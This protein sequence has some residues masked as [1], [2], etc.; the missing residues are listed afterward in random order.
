MPHIL[1]SRHDSNNSVRYIFYCLMWS[2]LALDIWLDSY[3]LYKWHAGGFLWQ[4][5]HLTL[6]LTRA[7]HRTWSI[8]CNHITAILLTMFRY[9][10]FPL[11]FLDMDTCMRGR[12]NLI[13]SVMSLAGLEIGCCLYISVSLGLLWLTADEKSSSLVLYFGRINLCCTRQQAIVVV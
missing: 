10:Y 9:D 3:I 12:S 7:I 5:H 8:I 11:G 6:S 4:D 13:L 2:L 1:W